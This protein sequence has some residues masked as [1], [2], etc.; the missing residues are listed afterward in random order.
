MFDKSPELFPVKNQYAY[1]IHCGISPLF[2]RALAKELEI[3]TEHQKTGAFLFL[4]K[5]D[6]VLDGLRDAGGALLK[7]D[8]ENIS[9]VKNTSEG[10]SQI[11]GGYPFE[12]GDE[13]VIY[14]NEYPANFYPWILQE[15]RGVRTVNL[16]NVSGD[17]GKSAPDL[18][19]TWSLSDLEELVTKK[20][21]VVAIS[22][23]QFTSGYGVDLPALA[24][25]CRE[26]NIDLVVDA[27]QSLGSLPL[28]PVEL[29]IA[30]IAASG[31]KWLLGPIGTGLLYSAPEFRAKLKPVMAGADL[32]K[33]GTDYLDHTWDPYQSGKMFEYSTSP[34]SLAAALEVCIREL[35]LRYGIENIIKELIRLQNLFLG[36]LDKDRYMPLV[37][38]PVGRSGILSFTHVSGDSQMVVQRSFD[39]GI[40]LSARGGL[41][42]FAPHV[43]NDEDEIERAIAVLN[44]IG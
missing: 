32:M 1:F 30:A 44:N 23:V 35:P 31:W 17:R 18:P 24:G 43:Y 27:A 40:A 6:E 38:P 33:Q 4:K 29:G 34:I 15:Q 12:P 8:P 16:Q 20:T 2:S 9:F 3:S 11:A 42:R 41:I 39:M 7:T 37:P 22:H 5:Y 26:R 14:T 25:F 36:K 21:K 28:Y 10:I 13:V 19:V